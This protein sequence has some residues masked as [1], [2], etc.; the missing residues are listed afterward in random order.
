MSIGN[1]VISVC[2]AEQRASGAEE[3]ERCDNPRSYAR[4]F[5]FHLYVIQIHSIASELIVHNTRQKLD[6]AKIIIYAM[7]T[8]N[9][10]N[11]FKTAAQIPALKSK[12]LGL[13]LGF[14]CG[15]V[16]CCRSSL[17]GKSPTFG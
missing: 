5:P 10:E 13:L 9:K 17:M 16:L 2:P 8:E 7:Q 14:K 4:H 1:T 11:T 6:V 15:A 3:S 12:L